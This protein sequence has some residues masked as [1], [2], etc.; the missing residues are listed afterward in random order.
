MMISPRIRTRGSASGTARTGLDA[1]APACWSSWRSS[2]APPAAG[3]RGARPRSGLA[4]RAATG[5]RYPCETPLLRHPPPRRTD[6]H[7]PARLRAGSLGI[8]PAQ[9]ARTREGARRRERRR[10]ESVHAPTPKASTTPE[11]DDEAAR[12]SRPGLRA[13]GRPDGPPLVVVLVAF[14]VAER[15]QSRG[16]EDEPVETRSSEEPAAP[17]PSRT[18]PPSPEPSATDDPWSQARRVDLGL[19]ADAYV[20]VHVNGDRLVVYDSAPG[21]H[22]ASNRLRGYR[23]VDGQPREAWSTTP[24]LEPKALTS[25]ALISSNSLIDPA[26]GEVEGTPGADRP[27]PRWSRTTSSSPAR[28][29]PIPPAPT[30]ICRTASSH[31]DG[32]PS[33]SPS[34]GGPPSP[35]RGTRPGP[36]S[37]STA[38]RGTARARSGADAG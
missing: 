6:L 16:P 8:I 32:D 4:A 20:R 27:R 1:C 30:G 14:T 9:A 3:R 35:G 15:L 11:R 31:C 36:R 7:P 12:R 28:A 5:A 2:P 19:S 22:G 10:A 33:P 13:P 38:T 17:P 34:S 23:L 26:T 18:T 21:D 37:R 25:T 29:D 24:L